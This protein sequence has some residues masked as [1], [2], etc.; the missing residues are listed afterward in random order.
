MCCN[1]LRSKPA[2]Q[3]VGECKWDAALI[4][5]DDNSV[6]CLHAV[7]AYLPHR[8]QCRLEANY[9]HQQEVDMIPIMMQENFRPSGWLGLLMGT[10]MWYSFWEAEKDDDDT[11]ERRVDP[12]EREIGNRGKPVQAS[13]RELALASGFAPQ[14]LPASPPGPV[15]APAPLSSPPVVAPAFPRVSAV[16]TLAPN[17]DSSVLVQERDEL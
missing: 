12:V 7:R 13:H 3:G 15:P 8:L 14:P 5:L 1:G 9:A 2:V 17:D 16:G 6:V 10:R 4:H 11:F